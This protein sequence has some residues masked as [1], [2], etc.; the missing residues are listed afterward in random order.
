MTLRPPRPS[1]RDERRALGRSP[2]VVRGFG[3]VLPEAM[4]MTEEEADRWFA[5]LSARPHGWVLEFEGRCIGTVSLDGVTPA[6]RRAALG[7]G[8]FDE[9]L[10]GLGLGTE[11]IQL[12]A[13]HAFRDLDLHRLGLRVIASNTRAV[14][15][16]EKCGFRIEGRERESALVGDAWEDDLVMGLLADEF[17]PLP[18][19]LTPGLSEPN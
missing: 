11:A 4:E 9:H 19:R 8:I 16:Y 5:G 3:A 6:D 2:E 7:I 14:R 12:V 17:L 18:G 15:C 10:L 1:D 13:E